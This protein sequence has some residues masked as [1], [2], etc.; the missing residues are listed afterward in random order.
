MNPTNT[1]KPEDILTPEELAQR[2]KVSIGWIY[3][4]S[5]LRGKYNGTPL[6]CLRMGRYLRFVWPEV[7]DWMRKSRR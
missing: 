2:L 7:V 6:P 5:R 1:L 4:K 3:E